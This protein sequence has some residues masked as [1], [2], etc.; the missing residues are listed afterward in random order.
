DVPTEDLVGHVLNLVA[1]RVVD[2]VHL[3]QQAASP[4]RA[5]LLGGG[6]ERTNILRQTTTTES[7][8]S[9]EEGLA[10]ATVRPQGGGQRGDVPTGGVAEVGDGIDETDLGGE[11]GVRAR[12]HQLRSGGIHHH[13]W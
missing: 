2:R 3:T 6:H 1:A 13:Q 8:T 7:E 11:E 12:L 9:V 5:E 4:G 10:D